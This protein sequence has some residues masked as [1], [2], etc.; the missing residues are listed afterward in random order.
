MWH[1]MKKTKKVNSLSFK[2]STLTL[3]LSE[4]A[5]RQ[6][7]YLLT[8]VWFWILFKSTKLLNSKIEKV[9][10]IS[11]SFLKFK[12]LSIPFSG[13]QYAL[14]TNVKRDGRKVFFI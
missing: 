12:Y 4:F 6:Q 2:Q 1:F 7:F 10:L 14:G 8:S 3:M 9:I 5:E 11:K 13:L